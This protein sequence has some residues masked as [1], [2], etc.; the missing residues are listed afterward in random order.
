[1]EKLLKNTKVSL[2]TRKNLMMA[3]EILKVKNNMLWKSSRR[4]IL[5]STSVK[6]YG[7]PN[8]NI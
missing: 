4:V 6:P 3:T 7:L 2:F 5:S 1:M 8:T